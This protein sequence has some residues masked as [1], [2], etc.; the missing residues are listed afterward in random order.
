MSQILV[1][2]H[3]PALSWCCLALA[4]TYR[5]RHRF[6]ISL[7]IW[8]FR[9]ICQLDIEFQKDP[10]IWLLTSDYVWFWCIYCW[11]KL[12]HQKNSFQALCLYCGLVF[13][14]LG[15]NRVFHGKLTWVFKAHSKIPQP[16]LIWNKNQYLF[17]RHVKIL[18]IV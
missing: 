1:K 6:F 17:I 14:N 4:V 5:K 18:A 13:E 8:N 10:R 16:I 9:L 12:Y 2:C 3:L 11:T 7:K 15:H